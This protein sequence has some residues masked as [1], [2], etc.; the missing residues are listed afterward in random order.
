[1]LP[2]VLLLV[3]LT[4]QSTPKAIVPVQSPKRV[5]CIVETH[6]EVE[7]SRVLVCFDED[8]QK[9]FE[10]TVPANHLWAKFLDDTQVGVSKV[11]IEGHSNQVCLVE[12]QI[13]DGLV[14]NPANGKH[15]ASKD[16][17]VPVRRGGRR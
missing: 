17:C 13:Q 12:V 14:R 5:E 15:K 8:S 2:V 4:Q 11:V 6:P 1:M 7:S 10:F 16:V 3:A 9:R